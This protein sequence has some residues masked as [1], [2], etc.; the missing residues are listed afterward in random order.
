VIKR[1]GIILGVAILSL[2][3]ILAATAQKQSDSLYSYARLSMDVA[4]QISSRYVDDVD[5]KDLIYSGIKGMLDILDPFSEFMEAKDYDRLQEA[6]KGKYSGLGMTIMLKDEVVTVV[7]PMEG[8]PAYRMGLK[9]GDKIVKIDGEPTQGMSTQEASNLMRGPAGTKV[10]LTID[11]EGVDEPL[12]YTIERAVIEIKTVPFYTTF[13][14]NGKKIGYVRLARFGEEANI[15][16]DEAFTEIL[17]ENPA[18]LIFDLRSN[19]GGLLD[20]A[21]KVADYFLPKG[22]EITSTRGRTKDQERTLYAVN[23]PL[24]PAS[25]PV[26]VLVNKMSASASEIVAGAI[27]D[28]DR[29]VVVGSETFGKGLVQQIFPLSNDLA[30]KLTTAKWYVPSGRCIQKDSRSTRHPEELEISESDSAD[31]EQ[32]KEVYYTKGGRIVYGGG[33]VGPDIEIEDETLNAL[34]LNLERLSL[35]FDFSISYTT[36]HPDLTE[37]F[38]VTPEMIAEFK[39]FMKEK[40]FTY[41]T[42]LENEMER[43]K[44]AIKESGKEADYASYFESL[45]KQIQLDKEKE[46][47]NSLDHIKRSI[48]RDILT[49]LYGEKAVYR[50]NVLKGDDYVMKAV[51]ILTSPKEYV[52]IL[53]PSQ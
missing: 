45:D 41:K 18:G 51:D 19:G 46:F 12:E 50:Q 30:L 35:F 39:K 33:G 24:I 13:E 27:Q 9:A 34:E 40:E 38:E 49:K 26:V 16:L 20:Q 1:T 4:F 14:Q 17:K 44:E 7:A 29:G 43:L 37:D 22:S 32:Q 21:V 47:D 42:K 23:D 11:R 3:I 36:E 15:E 52:G 6:T 5:S 31:I 8:T 28:W 53:H 10:A 48:K 2:F 25:L